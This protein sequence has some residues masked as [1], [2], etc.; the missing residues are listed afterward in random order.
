MK[1]ILVLGTS[2]S[3]TGLAAGFALMAEQALSRES[4]VIEAP[5]RAILPSRI[6]PDLTL[7]AP[8]STTERPAAARDVTLASVST[9]GNAGISADTTR[10]EIAA[11]RLVP[12]IAPPLAERPPRR[13]VQMAYNDPMTGS[14]LAVTEY[15]PI[16]A[17]NFENLPLI[18]VYR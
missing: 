18:G 17:G 5:S 7:P 6:P 11:I 9:L 2:L 1:L 4:A 15:R 14:D 10:E 12:L 3:A 13:P 8:Q 16:P